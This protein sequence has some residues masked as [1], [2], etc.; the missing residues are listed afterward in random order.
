MRTIIK[1]E[2]ISVW[3]FL[4]LFMIL[5]PLGNLL[6]LVSTNNISLWG[7]YFCFAI[8]AIGVDMLWGYTGVLCMCQAFF[9][10]LG[11]YGIAMHMLL[12]SSGNGTYGSAIPDFMIWNQVDVLPVFWEPFH[13]FPLALITT[14]GVTALFTLIFGFFIFVSRLRGVYFA[15]ITQALALA[16]WLI[17]LRNETMLGGT[18]GLT[19]FKTLMGFDLTSSS[20]K[21][22]L[23]L[24]SGVFLLVIYLSAKKLMESKFGKV[25]VAIRD[26]ESRVR[27]T[28]YKVQNYKL[29]IFVIAA[30]I[31]AIGGMLYVPQTGI[32]TPGRMDVR[33]SIEM[34]VWVA[35]GGRGNLK[36]AILGTIFVNF[37]YS[38]M[39][40][41]LPG[42]WLYILG[43]LFIITVLYMDKGLLGLPKQ[44]ADFVKKFKMAKS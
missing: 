33:A 13:S 26:S 35:L 15:I 14:L 25:L 22:G 8:A 32:I 39:T 36:G 29:T 23:Y 37:L 18:N 43:F 5:I 17:F 3:V 1:K 12:A 42:S 11:G 6:G 16:M 4:I 9:F 21:L 38:I 40:S 10:C 31:A 28:S 2:Y 30:V 41:I 19:D 44:L 34:I 7:R 27:Y 20:T 24:A